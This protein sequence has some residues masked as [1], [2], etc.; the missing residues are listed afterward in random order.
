MNA[1]SKIEASKPPPYH[2]DALGAYEREREANRNLWDALSKV[3]LVTGALLDEAD[4]RG[5]DT[6]T[7]RAIYD[8]AR[9]QRW[10]GA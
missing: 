7:R 1:M 6:A 9:E 4:R 5:E 10:A 3:L 8:Q 2:F